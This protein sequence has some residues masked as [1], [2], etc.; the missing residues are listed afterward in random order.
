[1]ADFRW[2]SGGVALI[3]YDDELILQLD[4]T[5]LQLTT[6]GDSAL[7]HAERMKKHMKMMVPRITAHYSRHYSYRRD[8][9]TYTKPRW[10][11]ECVKHYYLGPCLIERYW[12]T[13]DGW[14]SHSRGHLAYDG[15][16]DTKIVHECRL[17][18]AKDRT[19]GIGD[20]SMKA[21]ME[22]GPAARVRR[23]KQIILDQMQTKILPAVIALVDLCGGDCEVSW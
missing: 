4:A 14:D 7:F 11:Y 12:G 18:P 1:M 16:L 6:T 22:R 10:D 5:L 2:R 19:C 17:R 13:Y 20:Q 23:H 3:N 8:D 9:V 15:F 21:Q